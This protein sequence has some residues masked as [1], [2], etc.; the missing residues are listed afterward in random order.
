MGRR[1]ILDT[2]VLIAA[3]RSRLPLSSVI[4]PDDDV[5][6]ASVTL[7]ELWA[8]VDLA[9]STQQ[10]DRRA[11]FV[12]AVTGVLPVEPHDEA[13]ARV[14]GGLLATVHRLGKPR[15]AHDLRIAAVAVATDRILV[16]TDRNAG[17]GDLPGV[18]YE[19]VTGRSAS[20]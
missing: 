17:L 13:V 9:A 20:P 6:I 5:A 19:V 14:H 4:G 15:G 2:G 16:T 8:G 7:A 18:T 12:E 10:R 11:A 3:E 1:L